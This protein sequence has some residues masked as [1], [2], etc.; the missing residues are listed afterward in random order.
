MSLRSSVSI[1]HL[2]FKA[3]TLFLIGETRKGVRFLTRQSLCTQSINKA[4]FPKNTYV[5]VESK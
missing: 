4:S 5:K 1:A 2:L 3:Y